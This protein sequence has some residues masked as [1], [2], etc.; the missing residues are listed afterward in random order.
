MSHPV[1][2][3]DY[4]GGIIFEGL[5]WLGI[6]GYLLSWIIPWIKYLLG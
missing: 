5:I 3:Q 6:F 1:W 4:H 2:N